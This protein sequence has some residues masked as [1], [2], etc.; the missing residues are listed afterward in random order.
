MFRGRASSWNLRDEHMAQTLD[1][2]RGHLGAE[3]KVVVWAHN[4]HIGDARMTE[5]ADRGS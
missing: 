5:M 3:G 4:S 1:A 2:L